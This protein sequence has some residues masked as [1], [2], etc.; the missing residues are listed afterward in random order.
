MS[1]RE[2]LFY[3]PGGRSDWMSNQWTKVEC[4][5]Q[6]SCRQEQSGKSIHLPNERSLH[7]SVLIVDPDAAP[8]ALQRF[9][10]MSPATVSGTHG[11]QNN[12][13]MFFIT[14]WPMRKA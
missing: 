14:P 10:F 2:E 3:P 6:K 13:N 5:L 1:K 8:K 12:V 9:R 7:K 4:E 11:L